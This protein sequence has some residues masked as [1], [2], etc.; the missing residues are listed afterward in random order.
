MDQ[1]MELKIEAGASQVTN[2]EE[3]LDWGRNSKEQ[4]SI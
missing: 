3:R 2:S 4:Q 1:R